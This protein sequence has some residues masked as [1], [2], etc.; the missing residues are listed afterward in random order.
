[1]NY[2]RM[3]IYKIIILKLLHNFIEI[4]TELFIDGSELVCDSLR[5]TI[6]FLAAVDCEN[7]IS[8]IQASVIA[9]GNRQVYKMTDL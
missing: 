3:K 1:M 9:L 2:L 5:N 8:E 7:N 4:R 6:I